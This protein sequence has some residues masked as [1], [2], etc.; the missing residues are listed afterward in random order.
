MLFVSIIVSIRAVGAFFLPFYMYRSVIGKLP[1]PAGSRC[2][3]GAHR[4]GRDPGG[5]GFF[6]GRFTCTVV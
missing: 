6:F 2:R 1:R 3:Y 5:R 4:N